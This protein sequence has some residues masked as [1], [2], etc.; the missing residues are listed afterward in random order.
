[1]QRSC[2]QS[3]VLHS[4]LYAYTPNCLTSRLT[5]N[6]GRHCRMAPAV[7]SLLDA[8]PMQTGGRFFPNNAVKLDC[9]KSCQNSGGGNASGSSTIL[10]QNVAVMP[11]P[12]SSRPMSAWIITYL[13][14]CCRYANRWPSFSGPY[15][16]GGVV[17]SEGNDMPPLLEDNHTTTIQL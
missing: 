13:R 6:R 11:R 10:R 16:H 9:K 3:R 4:S 2:P 1:M 8:M 14:M 15:R 12:K 5:S 17:F 7:M